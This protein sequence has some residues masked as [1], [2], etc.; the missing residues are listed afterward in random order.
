MSLQKLTLENLPHLSHI[1]FQRGCMVYIRY[2]VIGL[3]TVLTEIPRGMET[4]KHLQNLEL[5]GM[6]TEFVDKLKQKNG[7][8]RYY[9]PASSDFYQA[10]R[11]L[12]C[13]RFVER[14]R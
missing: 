14:S 1:E 10:H 2:L 12:R 3:C 7:N 8:A 9:N 5:F 11:F 6:P 4:F 13:I